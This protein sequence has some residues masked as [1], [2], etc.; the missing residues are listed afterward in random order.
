MEPLPDLGNIPIFETPKKTTSTFSNIKTERIGK[1]NVLKD[2]TNMNNIIHNSKSP[3][4]KPA[5]KFRTEDNEI[6]RVKRKISN[7]A[8]MGLPVHTRNPA[9]MAKRNARERRRVQNINHTLDSL[10]RILP[11]HYLDKKDKN[12]KLSKLEI[13]RCTI[14]YIKSLQHI[15]TEDNQNNNLIMDAA[16]LLPNY[17]FQNQNQQQPAML[18]INSLSNHMG[19]QQTTDLLDLASLSFQ[20]PPQQTVTTATASTAPSDGQWILAPPTQQQTISPTLPPTQ[21][22][23]L[24]SQTTIQSLYTQPYDQSFWN[25]L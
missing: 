2:S 18:D 3:P 25:V 11:E 4:L 17:L 16:S 22:Q 13:L 5:K 12:K 14:D 6:L 19:Q 1:E 10:E 23:N 15:L 8:K 9:T 21:Q 20:Q 24:L 7:A